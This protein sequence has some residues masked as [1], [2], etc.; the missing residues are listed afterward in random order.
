MIVLLPGK[1]WRVSEYLPERTAVTRKKDL[2]R[3]AKAARVG[4]VPWVMFQTVV[5]GAWTNAVLAFHRPRT[6]VSQCLDFET[7]FG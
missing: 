1:R 6:G 3:N 5:G 7:P 2:C 4:P